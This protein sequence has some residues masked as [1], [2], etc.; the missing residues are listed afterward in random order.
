MSIFLTAERDEPMLKFEMVST[1]CVS[2]AMVSHFSTV[3]N[4]DSF[5]PNHS[6]FSIT[7]LS[8]IQNAAVFEGK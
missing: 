2:N 3:K 7:Y 6:D 1:T 4:P 5:I 8:G